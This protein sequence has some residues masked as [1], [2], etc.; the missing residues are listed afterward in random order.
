MR[1]ASK[2]IFFCFLV[3]SG[4]AQDGAN[5]FEIQS[6]LDSIYQSEPAGESSTIN[7]FD[8]VRQDGIS[9]TTSSALQAA[10]KTEE[11]SSLVP[12]VGEE[13]ITLENDVDNTNVV[14]PFDISHIPIRKSKLKK[15][16]NAFK[17]TAAKSKNTNKSEKGSNAFLFWLNLLTAFILAIVINTQR[18][19]ITKITKAITNENVLKLNHREEK[20]GVNGHYILLYFSFIVNA[21]IFAYLIL[22]SLY[23]QSGWYLF[24]LCFFGILLTYVVRHIFL[25]L[26]S[27]SFP[28]QKEVSLYGFTIETFNLFI[29]IILIPL[30]LIIAFGPEKI[31][32]PLIYLTAIIIGI[33]ILLRSFRGLLISSRWISSNLFHFLLYLCAFEILPILLFIKVIGS[34]GIA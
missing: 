8:V 21:A 18:G 14:N 34:F 33:L 12:E 25:S 4:S 13:I 10:D 1:L 24:Q 17:P 3:I 5:P 23:D 31:A 20:K 29:G 2:I 11:E 19:A 7:V 9:V 22:Y 6:R 28:I 27:S 15:E 30:N 32:V 16:A 26:L